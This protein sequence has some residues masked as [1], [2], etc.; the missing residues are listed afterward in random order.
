MRRYKLNLP[1]RRPD[2]HEKVSNPTKN[3]INTRMIKRFNRVSKIISSTK[4]E[5]L[6]LVEPLSLVDML[7]SPEPCLNLRFFEIYREEFD[8]NSGSWAHECHT[9]WVGCHVRVDG[10]ATYNG[11][12]GPIVSVREV[13]GVKSPLRRYS[14]NSC[15]CG[16][17]DR[18][19]IT[20][21]QCEI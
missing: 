3:K 15:S 20:R 8:A 1:P 16:S 12:M 6:F 11:L 18:N 9:D 19:T 14:R 2:V 21:C 10:H 7:M 4:I 17:F 13:V 5:T